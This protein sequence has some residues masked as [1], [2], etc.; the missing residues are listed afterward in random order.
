M[1]REEVD[2]DDT[3]PQAMPRRVRQPRLVFAEGSG[4]PFG[5]DF[6]SGG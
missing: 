4:Y 6:R 3:I 2:G 5:T 1:V